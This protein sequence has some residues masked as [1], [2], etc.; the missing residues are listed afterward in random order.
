[1]TFTNLLGKLLE[2]E[3]FISWKVKVKV[4][5]DPWLWPEKSYELGSVCAS[6]YPS[7]FPPGSFLR[8]GSLDFLKFSMV[9]GTH[10]VVCVTARF[11]EK[12]FA[13]KMGQSKVF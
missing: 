10:V 11:F 9:L 2:L 12:I 13:P 3:F 6:F 8:I 5:L 7:V 4:S 1:M